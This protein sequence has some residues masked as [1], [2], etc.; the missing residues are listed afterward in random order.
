MTCMLTILSQSYSSLIFKPL[1]VSSP[2]SPCKQP[3][4]KLEKMP[5]LLY[6]CLANYQTQYA[7]Y[8]SF[9][10]SPYS[11]VA[12]KGVSWIVFLQSLTSGSHDFCKNCSLEKQRL[13]SFF[14]LEVLSEV[15]SCSVL[16]LT[17]LPPDSQQSMEFQLQEQSVQLFLLPRLSQPWCSNSGS[18]MGR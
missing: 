15:E 4:G 14:V 10:E 8:L 3:V 18:C 16:V 9:C 7:C 2:E 1:T 13:R 11:Q 12:I 5:V 17:L 6:C